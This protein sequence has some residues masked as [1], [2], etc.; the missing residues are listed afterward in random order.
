MRT[1]V[2]PVG[3]NSTSVTR[4]V[5]NHGLDNGD[6]VRLL[7]PDAENA[8]R[9]AQETLSEIEL[10]LSELEPEI[11]IETTRLPHDDF[12]TAVTTCSQVVRNA[13][14]S[15]IAIFGGGAR[16]VFLP[17]TVAGLTHVD[18]IDTAYRYSDVD[19]AVRV[20][21]LPTLTASPPGATR[22]TLAAIVEAGSLSIPVLTDQTN[23]AKSTVTRHVA[24]LEA[25]DAV[26]TRMEGKVKYV[27]ATLTGELLGCDANRNSS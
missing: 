16:D 26:T 25:A 6:S 7:R 20:C 10:T 5:L 2:A 3:F 22:E 21:E 15:V 24:K 23:M 4:P 12:E 13:T 8:T 27:A 11:T 14:G 17:F 19:N 1:F 18:C 9:R